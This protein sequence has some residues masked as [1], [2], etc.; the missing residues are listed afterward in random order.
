MSG[1]RFTPAELDLI[2]SM[3]AIASATAW[4]DGD[5][6]KWTGRQR[7]AFANLRDK[8]HALM[9]DGCSVSVGSDLRI[10]K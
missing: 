3:C 2:N 4:G 5:Y 6:A 8:V 7:K 9:E 1:I 10:D